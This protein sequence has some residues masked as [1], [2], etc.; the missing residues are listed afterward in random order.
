[1]TWVMKK[2]K[3]CT[4]G[5]SFES[6]LYGVLKLRNILKSEVNKMRVMIMGHPMVSMLDEILFST[7]GHKYVTVDGMSE[8]TL[9]SMG[10]EPKK[11]IEFSKKDTTPYRAMAV[12]LARKIKLLKY[13]VG[14]EEQEM[15]KNYRAVAQKLCKIEAETEE[16][17]DIP[18]VVIALSNCYTV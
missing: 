9:H 12:E 3:Y 16:G 17:F 6:V 18:E 13:C 10:L 4:A 15:L 8:K 11:T 1:M 7:D 14:K 5:H 2:L